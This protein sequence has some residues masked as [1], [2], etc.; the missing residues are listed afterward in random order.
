LRAK[1]NAPFEHDKRYHQLAG[2]QSEIEEKLDLTKNQAPSQ[3]ENA[4][5]DETEEKVAPRQTQKKS[6]Q[7]AK[8]M[9]AIRV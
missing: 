2:R 1:V 4:A 5:D 7:P 6:K 8:K 9:A 3:I